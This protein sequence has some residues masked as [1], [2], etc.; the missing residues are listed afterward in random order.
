MP[1]A[2]L[3]LLLEIFFPPSMRIIAKRRPSSM[4]HVYGPTRYWQSRAMWAGSDSMYGM[5]APCTA[6]HIHRTW[7]QRACAC[8][9]GSM[10]GSMSIRGRRLATCVR[11]AVALGALGALGAFIEKIKSKSRKS[12]NKKKLTF[13]TQKHET[14]NKLGDLGT[15]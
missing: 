4:D 13:L 5:L 8:S 3:H 2:I 14:S 1:D 15:T 6:R 11:T 9:D 12:Q 7:R 10:D